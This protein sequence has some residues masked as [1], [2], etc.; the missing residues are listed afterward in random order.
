MASAVL[1][2]AAGTLIELIR[3]VGDS[4]SAIARAHGVELPA[5]RLRDAFA[6]VHARMPA[7]CFPELDAE[8]VPGRERRWWHDL[9]RQTFLAA[10]STARFPDF[11]ACFAELWCYFAAASSWR[12]RTGACEA[13]RAIADSGARSGVVS[14]FDHRLPDLLE[15]LEITAFIDCLILPGTHGVAKP[16]PRIFEPALAALECPASEAVY[17]GDE[18]EV[19]GLAARAAGLRFID[20]SQ[21]GSLCELLDILG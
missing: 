21:L 15:A 3:P 12:L 8:E 2:D 6:R 16:D 20:A 18:P 4:Y 1:F 19:D 13:L 17:V 7:M 9:V 5:W 10:D 11:E 14:N